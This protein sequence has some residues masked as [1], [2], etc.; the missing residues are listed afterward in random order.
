MKIT[1]LLSLLL[2]F[3]TALASR[4]ADTNQ[5][6]DIYWVDV[7]GGAATLI[8]TPQ[9]ESV[10]ID[11]G[12]AGGRDAGRIHQAAKA[13]GLEK[14]DYFILTHFHTDH[15]GGAAEVAQLIPIGTVLD[16]GIPDRNPD[17]N[18]ADTRFPLL[19][20]PYREMKTEKRTVIHP[21]DLIPLRQSANPGA[22]KLTLR[23]LAAAQS[24]TKLAPAKSAANPLCDEAK[25]KDKDTS[26]NANSVVTLLE[27]GGFRFFDGGDLTWN[28]E[29]NLVCPTNLVGVVDV[30]QVGHHGL[31]MS[32]NPLLVRALSPTV[33][34]MSNGTSKGCEPGTFATLSSV[35]SIKAGYQIHR[36]L[37]ADSQNNTANEY[38]ANLTEHCSGNYIK[39]SVAPDGTSYTVSIPA[40]GHQHSYQTKASA[41]N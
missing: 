11:S 41:Q 39:L 14:I 40:T 23:C 6:L 28:V 24:F 10:L 8:V 36:N 15:F 38:I 16:N 22:T 37:R 26:D 5:T 9:K 12:S 31:D 4:A 35:P 3:G 32:N 2:C 20:K 34:V 13:A 17:H 30:Y 21:D 27:F 25:L 19:I 7:E 33:T 18:P 29:A 1:T